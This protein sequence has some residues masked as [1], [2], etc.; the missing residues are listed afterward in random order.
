MPDED[1]NF[2]GSLVLDFRKRW[3]HMKMIYIENHYPAKEPIKWKDLD[4]PHIYLLDL[5]H[6]NISLN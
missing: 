2:G 3:R 4:G 1:K 6:A 5:S